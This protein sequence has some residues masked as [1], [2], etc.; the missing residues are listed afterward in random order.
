MSNAPAAA[1]DRE[2]EAFPWNMFQLLAAE[3]KHRRERERREE[4]LNFVIYLAVGAAALALLAG[5]RERESSKSDKIPMKFG[6]GERA[7]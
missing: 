4:R 2:E 6:D 3:Q 5:G 7:T 1:A